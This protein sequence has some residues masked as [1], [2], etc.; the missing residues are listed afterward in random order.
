MGPASIG[1]VGGKVEDKLVPGG[2]PCS[3]VDLI[4]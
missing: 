3:S 4:P 2:R 1:P